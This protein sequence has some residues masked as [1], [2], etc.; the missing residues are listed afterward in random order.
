MKS[1]IADLLELSRMEDGVA[2]LDQKDYDLHESIRRVLIG[3]MNDIEKKHIHL[4]LEFTEE[5]CYVF[6]DQAQNGAGDLQ[7]RGQR[8]QVSAT[9]AET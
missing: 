5:P 4:H 2:T 8:D 1:L 6:A 7:Y 3:R 9:T